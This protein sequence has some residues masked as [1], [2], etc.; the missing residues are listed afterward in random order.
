VT[1]YDSGRGKNDTEAWKND[2]ETVIH[3]TAHQTAFNTGVHN[4]FT[5]TPRWVVE[6]LGCL[7]EARGVYDSSHYPNVEDRINRGRLSSFRQI[8]AAGWAPGSLLSLVESDRIFETHPSIAYAQAW[9]LT[10]FLSETQPR[11][12][13]AYLAKTAARKDF[14][15]YAAA[16]RRADFTASFGSDLRMLEAQFLRYIAGLK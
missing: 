1:L 12:Y 14:E 8:V 4:R 10:M 16:Q 9:A 15:P 6:G 11:N 7:F 3:E 5:I 2:A 13:N